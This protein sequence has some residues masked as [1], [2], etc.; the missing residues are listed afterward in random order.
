MSIPTF[1]LGSIRNFGRASEQ[2]VHRLLLRPRPKDI[3][4]HPISIISRICGQTA[5][6]VRVEEIILKK[7]KILNV[8]IYQEI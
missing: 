1:Y 5:D 2:H 3:C 4:P 6:Q 8:S 7:G